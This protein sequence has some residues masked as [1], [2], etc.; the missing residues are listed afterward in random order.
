M[1]I[2]L[3]VFGV[4][5][6]FSF[7]ADRKKSD[8]FAFYLWSAAV[9]FLLTLLAG[10]RAST[11]GTDTTSYAL[12]L[13]QLASLSDT[14]VD[15][16]S[17]SWYRVW[18]YS[19][20]S[21]F[22]I[23]YLVLVWL[24]SRLGSFQILLS[25]TS[26]L[27]IAPIYAALAQK[28]NEVSLPVSMML[29][30]LVYF[31]TTL[32]GMR[33]WVAIAFVFLAVFALYRDDVPIFRQWKVI[34]SM[35][36]AFLFHTSAIIGVLLL[37]V[38]ALLKKGNPLPRYLAISASALVVLLA[39]GVMG[40]LLTVFGLEKYLTYIGTGSV[41]IVIS[42]LIL[43]VPFLL[44]ALYLYRSRRIDKRTAAFFLTVMTLSVIASQMAS[45]GTHS[46]RVSLYFVIF[47]IPLA[48]LVTKTF[49]KRNDDGTAV[50]LIRQP[51]TVTFVPMLCLAY[52]IFYW[53]YYYL[54]SGSGETV[55][56]MFFW[57]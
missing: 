9:V 5:V 50:S 7:L 20:V 53:V 35:L 47:A 3:V 43:Q 26:L 11:V 2:Y 19:E 12:P 57:Q 18:R 46:G 1:L 27:T 38:R 45:V 21:S 23:G 4:C 55:P 44:L 34:L 31:N 13:Y 16:N 41:H 32:N 56:Y 8:D 51:L 30:M 48:G 36:I 39:L 15:F 22:E 14:F 37:I 40:R 17:S 42:A 52:G 24:S 25:L 54:V 29:F 33:Q 10:L 49:T 6:F 28:R